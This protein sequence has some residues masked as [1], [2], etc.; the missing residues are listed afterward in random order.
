[1]GCHKYSISGMVG[2]GWGDGVIHFSEWDDSI[3]CLCTFPGGRLRLDED[4]VRSLAYLGAAVV[5]QH[6]SCKEWFYL[7]GDLPQWMR[8]EIDRCVLHG[9]NGSAE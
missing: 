7:P 4:T 9:K 1:M 8:D 6:Q 5:M 2:E 3:G